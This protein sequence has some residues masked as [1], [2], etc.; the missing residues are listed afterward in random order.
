MGDLR[1]GTAE[2]NQI[3]KKIKATNGLLPTA[4]RHTGNP[5]AQ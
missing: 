1:L 5:A 3:K 4:A 2:R